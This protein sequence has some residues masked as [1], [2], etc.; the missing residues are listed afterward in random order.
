MSGGR[1]LQ[2][3]T[4]SEPGF[5]SYF[6]GNTTDICPV[7]ALTTADFRFGA[8]PWELSD[9]PSIDPWDAA[10]ANLSLGMRLDRETGGRS[11]IKR[12]M[13]RQNEYVNE[14]W[15]SDKARFGHHFTRSADR[16]AYPLTDEA[17]APWA[18]ALRT[19][20]EQLRAAEGDIAIL[21]GSGLAN[22]DLYALQR[23]ADGLGD[24]RLG[25]WP[26][27]HGGADLVAQVGVG[28]GTN[29]GELGRGDVVLVIASDLEEE[30]PL[31]RLRLK[32]AADRGVLMLVA[33]ARGTRMDD[34]ACPRVALPDGSA[35]HF[36]ANLRE[37]D[38]Y[39]YGRMRD[40][41]NLVIVAGAEGLDLAGSRALMQAAANL[42]IETGHGRPRQQR[43]AVAAARAQR[44]GA[45]LSGLH[46]GGHAGH[47]GA[48]AQNAAG[49]AC[50]PACG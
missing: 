24:V 42:L 31:W 13:P 9:V 6:S 16:L 25:A 34:F 21:A 39:V 19:A 47:H 45:A 30:V 10:G 41:R 40:A 3:I 17:R 38:E 14:I 8:R 49:G 1:S 37:E 20:A 12:V 48:S 5:D 27:T 23:L 15:I 28:Q 18:E 4:N 43:P 26:P 29:L 32:Q 33:N 22:E 44:H 36:L 50:G 46:A 7:G 11:I 2:I 35:A